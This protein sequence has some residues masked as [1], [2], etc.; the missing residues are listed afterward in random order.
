VPDESGVSEALLEN[1]DA[2]ADLSD[3]VD[4]ASGPPI[5]NRAH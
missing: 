2:D 4:A 1:A 3:E 5:T